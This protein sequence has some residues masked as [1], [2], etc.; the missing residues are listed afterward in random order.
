MVECL[1]V[2][3][4]LNTKP[5]TFR[6]NSFLIR[7][8]NLKTLTQYLN[9]YMRGF[10]MLISLIVTI[11]APRCIFHRIKA[12]TNQNI[13]TYFYEQIH[14]IINVTSPR[15]HVTFHILLPTLLPSKIIKK[16]PHQQPRIFF[17]KTTTV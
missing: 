14:I 8:R 7:S 12:I 1:T 3:K 15:I 17:I 2:N 4:A 11:V 13:N 16:P 6:V 10:T 9:I 5:F